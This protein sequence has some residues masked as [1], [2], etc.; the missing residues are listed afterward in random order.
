M[1]SRQALRDAVHGMYPGYFA[2]VMAT[3]IIPNAFFLLDH[4]WISDALFAV[5]VVRFSFAVLTFD[6]GQTGADVVH[7]GW[8][9][10]IVGT[11]SLVLLA[12][13][14]RASSARSRTRSSSP[15]TRSGASGSSSTESS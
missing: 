2:L 11:E 15:S 1:S 6:E 10:A 4:G 14:S 7:G 12:L 3:G 13:L 5:S 8:L 9:I